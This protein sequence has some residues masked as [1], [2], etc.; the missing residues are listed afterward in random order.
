MQ[1]KYH[2]KQPNIIQ[3]LRLLAMYNPGVWNWQASASSEIE[4]ALSEQGM[5]DALALTDSIVRDYADDIPLHTS[6]VVSTAGVAIAMYKD[7]DGELKVSLHIQPEILMLNSSAEIA[8]AIDNIRYR[9]Q[10]YL[11]KTVDM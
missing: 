6:K 9:D 1:Q 8:Q 4:Y 2:V 5:S 7:K 3:A 11:L 10:E